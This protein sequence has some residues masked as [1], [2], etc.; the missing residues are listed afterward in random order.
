MPVEGKYRRESA[1]KRREINGEIRKL[2]RVR[3]DKDRAMADSSRVIRV[4]EP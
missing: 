1:A 3:I 4:L 2:R